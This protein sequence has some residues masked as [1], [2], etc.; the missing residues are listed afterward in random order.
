MKNYLGRNNTLKNKLNQHLSNLT[1]IE[2]D[3]YSNLKNENILDLK[4]VLSD[5]HNLLT[6]KLTIAAAK[7]VCEYFKIGDVEFQKIVEKVDATKP[8]QSGFDILIHEPIKL[9]GEVKCTS[10]INNGSKFGVTQ[11]NSILNDIQKLKKGKRELL[12]T[13][14]YLKFMFIIDLGDRS[15]NAIVD[16]LKKTNIRI[17]TEGRLNRNIARETAVIFDES[18]VQSNLDLNNVYIKVIKLE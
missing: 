3:Y 17:E 14:E 15:A 5:I 11:R 4:T 18:T 8:N 9:V 12:D 16:I 13:S 7:W 1:G 2:T 10:P 6:L